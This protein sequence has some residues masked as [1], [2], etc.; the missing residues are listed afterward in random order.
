MVKKGC[1]SKGEIPNFNQHIAYSKFYFIFTPIMEGTYNGSIGLN[2]VR[3]NK[4]QDYEE[5][6]AVIIDSFAEE[7]YGNFDKFP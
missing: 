2:E 1:L 7:Q 4:N 3:Q 5:L 6:N